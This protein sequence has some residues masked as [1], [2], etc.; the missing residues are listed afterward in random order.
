MGLDALKLCQGLASPH[1]PNCSNC[2]ELRTA[3]MRR[4][5]LPL[6]D[7][8]P[9]DADQRAEIR[10]RQAKALTVAGKT[11]CPETQRGLRCA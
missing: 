3:W 4:T 8:L 9:S 1:L 2:F 5:S 6:V 7:R 10:S 11:R